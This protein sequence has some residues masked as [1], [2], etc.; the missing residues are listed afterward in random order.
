MN[1]ELK[2][3]LVTLKLE[4]ETEIVYYRNRMNEAIDDKAGKYSTEFYQS[5]LNESKEYFKGIMDTLNIIAQ[6]QAK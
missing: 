3:K 2:N 1:Q 6:D 5:K 4:A